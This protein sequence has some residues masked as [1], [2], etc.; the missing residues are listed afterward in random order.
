MAFKAWVDRGFV[1]GG[2]Y[3]PFP[4]TAAK[5][6][7]PYPFPMCN[8][9][10]P[11]ILGL[12]ACHPERPWFQTPKCET[13]CRSDYNVKYWND[14]IRGRVWYTLK[15][16]EDMMRELYTNG[17]MSIAI[18]LWSDLFT[19]KSGVYSHHSGT[20]CGGHAV[21]LFGWGEENGE[22]YWLIQNE[23]N[24]QWGDK[25]YVKVK[26][27]ENMIGVESDAS[28][29]LAAFEVE[30]VNK[31]PAPKPKA[32]DTKSAANKPPG[33]AMN[34]SMGA[35]VVENWDVMVLG[36]QRYE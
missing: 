30:V 17:P 10:I 16:E 22:K 31:I 36:Q 35:S 6:C 9:H 33:F 21:N 20:N 3:D 15:G 2:N 25:G 28:T 29:G 26:R 8:H 32:D 13:D 7:K 4:E 18:E 1:S 19:Y 34:E 12:P 23:W 27:G 5:S 24:S 11:G 14:V